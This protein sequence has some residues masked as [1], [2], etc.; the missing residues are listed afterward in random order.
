[1]GSGITTPI[2]LAVFRFI[3]SS[4]VVGCSTGRSP[5]FVPFRILSAYT[6]AR[7]AGGGR[8]PVAAADSIDG[9]GGISETSYS[10]VSESV[11]PP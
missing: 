3:T 6:A 8:Y 1:M 10:P 5:G 7:S 11:F 4:N 2:A 9:S